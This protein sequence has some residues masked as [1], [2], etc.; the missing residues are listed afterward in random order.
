MIKCL[1]ILG[2][3]FGASDNINHSLYLVSISHVFSPPFVPLS[4]CAPPPSNHREWLLLTWP[5]P[6]FTNSASIMWSSL[7]RSAFFVWGMWMSFTGSVNALKMEG[8]VCVQV[9]WKNSCFHHNLE[10]AEHPAQGKNSNALRKVVSWKN[11]TSVTD[12]TFRLTTSQEN[13]N[14]YD[15][16]T[17]STF[18]IN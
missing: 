18:C 16:Y 1:G 4:G 13:G 17:S 2:S 10:G 14:V 12:S 6:L 5:L 3:P 11:S 7:S 8:N 9:W 15:N